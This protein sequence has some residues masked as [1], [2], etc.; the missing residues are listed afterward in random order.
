MLKILCQVYTP[1]RINALT[2]LP[3]LRWFCMVNVGHIYH[4]LILWVHS[5]HVLQASSVWQRRANCNCCSG[6]WTVGPKLGREC[7]T[8]FPWCWIGIK[9]WYFFKCVS[10]RRCS[11]KRKNRSGKWRFGFL[12][13]LMKTSDDQCFSS[14]QVK[15]RFGSFFGNLFCKQAQRCPINIEWFFGFAG[16][17]VWP[18]CR[19]KWPK[20]YLSWPVNLYTIYP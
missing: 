4:A 18:L 15:R 6:A 2:C 10:S 19:G 1:L 3:T 8:C 14:L 20:I 11:S 9:K 17:E 13:N 12:E 16:R 7:S 5:Y